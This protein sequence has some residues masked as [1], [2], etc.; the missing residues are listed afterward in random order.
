MS[1]DYLSHIGTESDRF[2]SAL[3]DADPT[4]RVPSCPDWD[5]DDLLWHLGK[6]Q[7][8]WGTIVGQR[9]QDEELAEEQKPARPGSHADLVDFFTAATALLRRELAAADPTEQVWMWSDDQ[10]VGYVRRRQ[11]HEALIHRLDAEL[12]VGAVSPLDAVLAADGVHE[13]LTKFYGGVP[14]WG[15]FTPTGQVVR[16]QARDAELDLHVTL[17]RFTGTSPTTGAAYDDPAL[18]L[19]ASAEAAATVRGPAARL[20]AWVW[21]REALSSLDVEGDRAAVAGLQSVLDL[22]IE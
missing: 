8:F 1:L 6:V 16:L 21:G 5:A 19:A 7:W 2:L 4:L 12:T 9:L 14:D 20:D 3:R 17:G 11:A 10:S 22:G 15:T 13:A 18:D